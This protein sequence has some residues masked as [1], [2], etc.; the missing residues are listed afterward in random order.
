MKDTKLICPSCGKE[1]SYKK[2]I[3]TCECGYSYRLEETKFIDKKIIDGEEYTKNRFG[4]TLSPLRLCTYCGSH[5]KDK[6]V[7][8]KECNIYNITN[9]ENG[10]EYTYND[11][12]YKFEIE[13]YSDNNC[14]S[15]THY[16]KL[17]L[18]HYLI[19]EYETGYQQ[20]YYESR[21]MQ[22]NMTS[23]INGVIKLINEDRIKLVSGG[24]ILKEEDGSL[25][26][27]SDDY[28]NHDELF[29]LEIL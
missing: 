27:L 26:V 7:K 28:S 17:F 8:Y 23:I 1:I 14:Y 21:K 6:D 4:Y 29:S 25:S 19:K 16:C 12:V 9:S 20:R 18:N 3:V 2:Y 13:T 15:E 10:F 5:I 24:I 22:N 11:K